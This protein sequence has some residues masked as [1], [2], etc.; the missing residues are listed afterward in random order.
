MK[1]LLLD[2]WALLDYGLILLDFC[3]KQLQPI[4]SQNVL[5]TLLLMH[6]EFK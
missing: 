5:C 2:E 6:T 4:V 1:F 3:V